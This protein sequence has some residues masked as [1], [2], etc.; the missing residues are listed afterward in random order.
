MTAQQSFST[1][2][3]PAVWQTIPILEFLQQVW[4]TMANVL[5]FYELSD[6][7][8]GG[9]ENLHKWYHKTNNTNAYFICLGKC[10]L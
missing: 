7:I 2:Q 4:E 6:A 9:L 8:N 1:S 10:S 5:K 3:D